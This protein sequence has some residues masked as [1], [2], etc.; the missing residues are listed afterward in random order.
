MSDSETTATETSH[1]SRRRALVIALFG[2]GAP[3]AH[4]AVP[5]R[6][7]S[8]VVDAVLLPAHAATSPEPETFPTGTF[9]S[10]ADIV[11]TDSTLFESIADRTE[12]EILNLFVEAAE[13]NGCVT[14]SACDSNG[15]VDV[16]VVATIT[17]NPGEN[18]C[19]QARV[20][21]AGST[22]CSQLC[23]FFDFTASVD[24][25]TVTINES[26]ELDLQNM[27]LTEAGLSGQWAYA[28]GA[29]NQ[30]D[31]FF[32]PAD[33]SGGCGSLPPCDS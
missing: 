32:S 6:W 2:A 27:S 9:G 14:N 31:N 21:I 17:E 1:R 16:R 19:V 4:R 23:L 10:G 20:D 7:A 25:E 12:E 24:G 29:V 5:E 33:G 8:P 30:S 18:Q 13:A 22:S 11:S 15:E 3:L 26:C 28:S